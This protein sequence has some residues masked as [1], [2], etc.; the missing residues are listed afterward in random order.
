VPI[1]RKMVDWKKKSFSEGEGPS[2]EKRLKR[3]R[4]RNGRKPPIPAIAAENYGTKSWNG[5][6]QKS[7]NAPLASPKSKKPWIKS[8]KGMI[9][10]VGK[11]RKY[12]VS[13]H[14]RTQTRKEEPWKRLGRRT[15]ATVL[16]SKKRKWRGRRKKRETGNRCAAR[17][18]L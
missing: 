1:E 2:V 4:N 13:R 15:H 17:E 14:N 3:R 16:V 9:R 6:K 5:K 8:S 7:S 11:G 18:R 10:V 12:L